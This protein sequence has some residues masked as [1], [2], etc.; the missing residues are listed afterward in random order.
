M[1]RISY[2]LY[3]GL[4]V[5]MCLLTSANLNAQDE[6][7]IVDMEKREELKSDAMDAMTVFKRANPEMETTLSNAAGYVVFPN[8]GKGAWILGGAAG[9]GVVYEKGEVA[10]Y[11]ELRQIDI[12]FQFGGKA[13]R[14]LIV[15]KT[16]EALDKFKEG[17][18]EFG[19]SASAVIWDEGKGKALTF[20]DGVGVAIIPKAGVMAGISVGGQEFDFRAVSK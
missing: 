9:N 17:N 10:G 12:G 5:L 4:I 1:K 6:E 7:V 20:E 15:F 18:F 19:G 14:E 8:V 16:P 13:F 11:A 2:N 3:G